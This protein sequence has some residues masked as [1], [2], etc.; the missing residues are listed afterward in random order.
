[1]DYARYDNQQATPSE[2]W[3]QL[4]L[5]VTVDESGGPA[6]NIMQQQPQQP[7]QVVSPQQQQQ[8]PP[9]PTQ[10]IIKPE[11]LLPPLPPP[12]HHPQ[13][14]QAQQIIYA[15][16]T[17]Q[18]MGSYDMS[19]NWSSPMTPQSV[20]QVPQ[21]WSSAAIGGH[22][23]LAAVDPTGVAAP[24]LRSMHSSSCKP[25]TISLHPVFHNSSRSHILE[26]RSS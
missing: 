5:P 6:S 17:H 20:I 19:V 13:H 7:L 10:Q 14:S 3:N 15:A 1:M 22:H 26:S 4:P 16:P 25:S 24:C 8:P 18:P 23:Q 21:Q 2:P 9:A 11:P 12:L